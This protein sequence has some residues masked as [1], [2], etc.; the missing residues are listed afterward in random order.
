MEARANSRTRSG[1]GR[2]GSTFI[3]GA[4]AL[5]L[6]LPPALMMI[7]A[8][9]LAGAAAGAEQGCVTCHS[10]P[11][12]LVRNKKLYDYFQN[13][14][15]SLHSQEGVSCANCHGGNPKRA[16]KKAAH[17]KGP[18]GA[19]ARSSPINYRNIPRTCSRC[20][21][22]YYDH[23][24]RSAHFR[25]LTEAKNGEAAPNC[26]T[27]HGSVNTTVLSVHTVAGACG[28]CHN[29]KTG[30]HPGIPGRAEAV[31]NTFLSIHRYYRY[32][33]LRGEPEDVRSFSRV[34]DPLIQEIKEDW[35]K[36][37]LDR[38]EE[39]TKDLLRLLKVKRN[40][41]RAHLRKG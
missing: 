39:Q 8:L 21:E 38:I 20:H 35:H 29:Q 11:S 31:L 36:S 4:V 27:C 12:F 28:R 15:L 37:D 30:N 1:R 33:T 3:L 16:D 25:Q 6:L 19:A 9:T 10:D 23:F 7:L 2:I 5:A 18:M 34:V 41:I 40:Q 26:V 22:Q 13:W 32:I 14:K 24:R 17:A